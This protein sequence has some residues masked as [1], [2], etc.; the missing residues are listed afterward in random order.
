[1][2]WQLGSI[3]MRLLLQAWRKGEWGHTPKGGV[4]LANLSVG[5]VVGWRGGVTV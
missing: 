1:M 3:S 5:G 4:M 2:T